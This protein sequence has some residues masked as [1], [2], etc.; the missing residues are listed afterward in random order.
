MFM[1]SAEAV[2]RPRSD[3]RV[4]SESPTQGLSDDTLLVDLSEELGWQDNKEDS[5]GRYILIPS[6]GPNID[7]SYFKVFRPIESIT[8]AS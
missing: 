2:L 1:A 3:F 8:P 6:V 7:V 5:P 4:P